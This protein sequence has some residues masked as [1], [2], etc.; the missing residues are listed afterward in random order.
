MAVAAASTIQVVVSPTVAEVALEEATTS[1]KV[2]VPV[3][4]RVVGRPTTDLL[5]ALN[6]RTTCQ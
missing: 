1:S 5:T 2:V 6:L 4:P 3:A